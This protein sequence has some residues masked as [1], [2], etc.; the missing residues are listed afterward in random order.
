MMG[1]SGTLFQGKAKSKFIDSDEY[2]LQ[3]I[4]YVH[5]NP[6]NAGLV[7][8]PEDWLFSDYRAWLE[9]TNP[10]A[11][12][13]LSTSPTADSDRR[14]LMRDA[15]FASGNKYRQFVEEYRIEQTNEKLDKFLF[16]E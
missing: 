7:Q 14:G 4:C 3:V 13:D 9:D 2:V 5:L 11:S 1:H 15:Y 16:K 12:R 10:T 6:V 8:K